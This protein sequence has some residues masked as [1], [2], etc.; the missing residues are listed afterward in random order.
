MHFPIHCSLIILSI[1]AYNLSYRKRREIN[2]TYVRTVTGF[3][4]E[5][6][7][8]LTITTCDW[9]KLVGRNKSHCV[10][11]ANVGKLVP[12]LNWETQRSGLF[13]DASSCWNYIL[14]VVDGSNMSR[15]DLWNHTDRGKPSLLEKS[16]FKCRSVHHEPHT[17]WP[18]VEAS[19]PRWQVDD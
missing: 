1:A 12:V 4:T 7:N 17:K 9:R 6:C 14:S 11:R 8:V 3:V 13:N 18:G 10:T 19:P 16:P 2:K 15:Q 5:C